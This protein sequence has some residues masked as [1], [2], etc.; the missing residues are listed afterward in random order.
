MPKPNSPLSKLPS[1]HELIRHPQVQSVVDRI[2]QT[3][4]AGRASHFLE[5]LQSYLRQRAEQ[6]PDIQQI[7]ERFARH[8]LGKG[9]TGA[10]V[11]N[12]T[13][14][15]LGAELIVGPLA[16]VAVQE[17][18]RL[19]GEY[20]LAPR[21]RL[22]GSTGGLADSTQVGM[23]WAEQVDQLLQECTGAESAWVASSTASAHWLI[24]LAL[25]DTC[26]VL[27]AGPAGIVDPATFGLAGIAPISARLAGENRIVLVEG[28]GMLGGPICGIVLGKRELVDKLRHHA[29]APTLAA[30]SLTLAALRATLNLYHEEQLPIQQIPIL[31]L[32]SVSLEN[33]RQRAE[34]LA[35][36]MQEGDAIGEALPLEDESLWCQ[37]DPDRFSADAP[38]WLASISSRTAS[39]SSR[40]APTW[41]ISLRPAADG[42]EAASR[43]HHRLRS[44]QRPVLARLAGDRV[45]LDLRSVF[46]RWDQTLV[47]AV[48]QLG[49]RK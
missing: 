30:N 36:L 21:L 34:R 39:V 15:V 37:S 23:G 9:D 27:L 25:G 43:L 38:P 48:E 17:I 13:G 41:S 33:L 40:T 49:G 7:A 12:A 44:G 46:P 47:A 32:L 14:V 24:Q 1:I 26:E 10:S 31:Q 42:P 8:L 4:L 45:N 20:H 6:I 18:V 35:P 22:A 5:E 3:T 29:V 28:A 11:I 19:A 16:E 2:N